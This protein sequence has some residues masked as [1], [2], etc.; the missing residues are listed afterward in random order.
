MGDAVVI[1]WA[2]ILKAV[3]NSRLFL[4]TDQLNHPEVCRTTR[5]RFAT[6][7]I[8]SERLLLEGDSPRAELLAAYNRIDVALDPFPYPGG[9][10]SVEGLWMGVPFITRRGNR[11]LSHIGESIAHN[12]GLADWIAADDDD[13]VAKAVKHATSL[14]CLAGLR[15]Q[16]RQQVLASPLFDA[17]RFARNF[18]EALWCLWQRR[19]ER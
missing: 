11:F 4:K 3:P 17:P 19:R 12:A 8:T 6:C 16:L 5:Q 1:L 13:Y 10:T 9:T 2:R 7:G 18:E 14:E 15:K